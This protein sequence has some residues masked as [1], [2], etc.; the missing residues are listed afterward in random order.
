MLQ[1]DPAK[2]EAVQ[3]YFPRNI[4]Q[5]R[6]VQLGGLVKQAYD[7]L[8]ALQRDKLWKLEGNYT[9]VHE[10]RYAANQISPVKAAKT[11]FDKEVEGICKVCAETTERL[12]D[13]VHCRK[14]KERIPDLQRHRHDT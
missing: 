5:G 4:D 12:A 6:A 3:V 9:L 7:Q 11:Q 10:L 13:R 2:R 14:R 8:E 1:S